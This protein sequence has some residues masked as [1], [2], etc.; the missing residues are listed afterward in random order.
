MAQ[1]ASVR[2]WGAR[3]C[4][5]ESC[6][7]DKMSEIKNIIGLIATFL[8]F[9]GYIPYLRDIIKGK[10]KPHIYTWFLWCFVT[11]IA[12]ALQFSAGAGSGSFVTLVSAIMCA[13]VIILG[14]IVKS[15]VKIVKS[16]S[17]F[18]ILAFISLGL[19]LIA[20]QPILSI[21]LTTLVDLFG[22]APTVRKSYNDPYSETLS[23]YWLN[24]FRF[25]LAIFSLQTYTLVTALYPISWLSANFI[26]AIMLMVR[27]QQISK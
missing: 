6:I 14:F 18:L 22:F 20:K 21:I 4:R 1:L 7:S 17:I 10:T 3:G 8:V 2:A 26:F 27:R 16:D 19:W 25:S 15:K 5:F 13:V 12:F 23:F 11:F 9:I 24:S